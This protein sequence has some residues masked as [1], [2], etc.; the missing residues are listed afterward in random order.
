L[1]EAVQLMGHPAIRHRGTVGGSLAHADPAAELPAAMLALQAQVICRGP[2]AIRSISAE[3]FFT[4]YLT[5]ALAVDELVTEIRVPGIPPGTGSA[6][7]EMARRSGDFAICGAAALVTLNTSGRVDSVR[8]A[9][10]GVG[11]GPVRARTV[12]RA[13]VGELPTRPV[14]AAAAQHVV[15]EID[16]PS[17][18]HGS[19]AYRR[20][21]AVVMTRRAVELAAQRAGA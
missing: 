4:G 19:A 8:I 5:T 13:L 18:I 9:L 1:A 10:C 21:L 3:E 20:K 12:E 7:L 15:D 6:F 11:S 16:P 17:D 2:Q 14:V